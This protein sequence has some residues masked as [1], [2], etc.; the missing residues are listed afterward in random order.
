[1]I[2]KVIGI[3]A[4]LFVGNIIASFLFGVLLTLGGNIQSVGFNKLAFDPVIT[5]AY[6]MLYYF[7][8]LFFQPPPKAQFY[9]FLLTLFLS[10]TVSFL[11]GS[12]YLVVIY[13]LLKKFNII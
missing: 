5:I 10:F 11:Q 12:I 4:V 8:T 2:K 7:V 6:M 13:Y 9:L 1:M 3:I